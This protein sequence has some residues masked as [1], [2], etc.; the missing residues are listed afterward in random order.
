MP[1]V[2]SKDILAE[3]RAKGYGVPS[4]LAGNL[5]MIVGTIRAA[6]GKRSPF[7]LAF[8]QEV[9]PQIPSQQHRH[10]Q[11]AIGHLESCHLLHYQQDNN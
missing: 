10:G 6:E 2:N 11:M 7:I 9:T 8:N 1:L 4:L 3:A 5:E